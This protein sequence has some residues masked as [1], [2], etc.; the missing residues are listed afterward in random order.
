VDYQPL[1]NATVKD[2]Y[3][4]PLIQE[5]QDNIRG[6][7]WFTKLDITDTYYCV[8]IA[9]GEEW[10]TAFRSKFGHYK[11]LVMSFGLTNTPATF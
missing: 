11:Y 8:R 1:N 3:P 7:K 9:K 10:K 4:L 6:V 5:L 2:R